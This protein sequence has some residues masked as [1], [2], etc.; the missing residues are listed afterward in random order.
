MD[1]KTRSQRFETFPLVSVTIPSYNAASTLAEALDSVLGQTYPNVEVIVV[2]D[3]STDDTQDVLN[4]YSARVNS[5]RQKNGGL[6][7]ARNTGCRAAQ[8]KYIALMDADDICMPERIAVQ[9]A[10]ME[11]NP[12]IVMCSSDFV[13]FDLSGLIADSYIENYYSRVAET[14][15]GVAGIYPHHEELRLSDYE[16]TTYS[17]YVYE[18]MALGSFI[19]PPTVLFRRSILDECGLLDEHVVNCCDF[20]WFVR[21]S[22]IGK[23]GFIDRSLLKYRFSENQMSGSRN[24]LQ[25]ALDIVQ[26][27]EKA[28][29]AD[30]ALF[31]RKPKLFHRYLGNA[32]L[33]AAD[34]LVEG[35]PLAAITM[36]VRS[37]T[38]GVVCRQSLK[39]L[40]KAFTPRWVLVCWRNR[41]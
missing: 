16:V 2:D 23:I 15:G 11:Q 33:S 34:A 25:M 31:Q 24:G 40:V 20:D 22:R 30:L 1:Q 41:Y 37:V 38:H 5:I 36:L 18:Q 3:G 4:R 12:D 8:G 39:V 29:A 13:A 35:Q 28:I 32:Y 26:V 9:V 7:S 17:G 10:Y 6:A 27:M 21:M 14:T 19:H